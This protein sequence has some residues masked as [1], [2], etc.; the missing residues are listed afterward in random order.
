MKSDTITIIW[1]L[2]RL[3]KE[4]LGLCIYIWPSLWRCISMFVN[5]F[6]HTQTY[7]LFFWAQHIIFL[8]KYTVIVVVCLKQLSA[9]EKTSIY[10]MYTNVHCHRVDT[11]GELYWWHLPEVKKDSFFLIWTDTLFFAHCK[12]SNIHVFTGPTYILPDISNWGPATFTKSD[13]PS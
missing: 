4:T 8:L 10:K 3:L 6:V 7:Q 5:M 12:M 9:P 11:V 13:L 2:A 1:V